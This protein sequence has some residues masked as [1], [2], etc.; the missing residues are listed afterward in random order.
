[1]SDTNNVFGD[2][3]FQGE[4]FLKK[5]PEPESTP[6]VFMTTTSSVEGKSISNYH[7]LAFGEAAFGVGL[8]TE[9][10]EVVQNVFGVRSGKSEHRMEE[11]RRQ[12]MY[13]AS[14]HAKALGA[15]AMVGIRVDYEFTKGMM[16]VSIS[17]TA[18]SV[19]L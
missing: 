16:F 7:G 12:A 17:G 6:L 5:Y 9:V 18:V 19:D 8:G 11:V 4:S 1:M 15:N 13:N 2:D 14:E 10:F 3:P